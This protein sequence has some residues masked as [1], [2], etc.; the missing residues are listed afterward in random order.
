MSTDLMVEATSKVIELQQIL[1]KI[2]KDHEEALDAAEKIQLSEANLTALP[3]R[4][5]L[6]AAMMT[7]T[8]AETGV[9]HGHASK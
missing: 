4:K 6:R 3:V 2:S 5:D 1:L 7:A 9:T 8:S